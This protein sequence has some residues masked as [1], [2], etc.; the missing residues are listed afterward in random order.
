M[1]VNS[2]SK[3]LIWIFVFLVASFSI[4]SA[5]PEFNSHIEKNEFLLGDD[6]NLFLNVSNYN[7][8]LGIYNV[9]VDIIPIQE[10]SIPLARIHR[11]IDKGFSQNIP[12]YSF[13]ITENYPSG[14]Y[15]FNIDIFNSNY[16]Q[17]FDKKL[18]FSISSV[19]IF[20]FDITL[21]KKVF[22]QGEQINIDYTSSVQNP[23]LQSTLK[24]PDDSNEEINLPTTITASQIGT[25]EIQV[26][27]TKE[28]YKDNSMSEQFAV[29]EGDVNIEYEGGRDVYESEPD[30]DGGFSWPENY[31]IYILIGIVVFIVLL[32]AILIFLILRKK[33]S[34]EII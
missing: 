28:G 25:Y 11:L 10:Q 4:I 13:K 16:N 12:I 26:T 6:V 15:F 7:V 34:E 3:K 2:A 31:L 27:A 20:S 18:F 9:V 1:V 32:L 29:I 8:S 33:S 22:I 5:S 23:S 30:E 17:V 24:Y 14:E 19:E 21:N